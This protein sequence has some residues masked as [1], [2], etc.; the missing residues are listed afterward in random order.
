MIARRHLELLLVVLTAFSWFRPVAAAERNPAVD[1][2]SGYN[3]TKWTVEGGLPE[4]F[5]RALA[6]TPDG[7]L[8]VATLNGLARF[9]GN[10]FK[11]FDHS[12]T[13]EMVHESINA[14][15][16][17]LKTGGLWIGT[18]AGLL[19]YE[20]HR[21]RRFA[22]SDSDS[23]PLAVGVMEPSRQGGVWFS[24]RSGQ[25][26]LVRD[27]K[28]ATWNF[29][30]PS[31]GFTVIQILEQAS[32]SLLVGMADT[33]CVVDWTLK[34]VHSVSQ[35][36]PKDVCHRFFRDLRGSFWVCGDHGL[37]RQ[38]ETNWV[39]EL[40]A[41]TPVGP[42]LEQLGQTRDGRILVRQREAGA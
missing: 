6:Q 36:L 4:S 1:L 27:G 14:L 5:V 37:W 17:D 24:S 21:F 30:P 16:V 33:N 3:A 22:L 35:G 8:W 23:A 18:G 29:A 38:T 34:R 41:Q 10:Q 13:P 25:V 32:E 42:W 40:A 12:T 11:V 9:D 26:G 28:L 31:I 39:K 7:Y 20:N 2:D 19:D 15:A